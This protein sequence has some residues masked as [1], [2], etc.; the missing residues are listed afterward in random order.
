MVLAIVLIAWLAPGDMLYAHIIMGLMFLMGIVTGGRI[1]I[2]YCMMVDFA[3]KR[4]HPTLG[5]IWGVNEGLIYIWLT[6]YY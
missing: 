2:G 5:A 6:I 3:P 4:T 1:A